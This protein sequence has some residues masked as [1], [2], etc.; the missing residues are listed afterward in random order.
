MS[1]EGDRSKGRFAVCVENGEYEA[2]LQ[3][4]KFYEVLPDPDAERHGH[5]RVIDECG[6][7]YLYPRSYFLE[8]DLPASVEEA[9]RRAS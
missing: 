9:L 3:T 2:S 4:R 1:D 7:D 5:I 8:L 6:E